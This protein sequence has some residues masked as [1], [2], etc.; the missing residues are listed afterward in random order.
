ML[1][2]EPGESPY[3]VRFQIFGFPVR[4]AWTFWIAVLVFGYELVD[5]IDWMLK[6]NSPGRLPL[7]LLWAVCLLVSILI[8]ELGHAFAFR[9]YGI[10]S[11]VILYHFGGLAVPRT[12][13][14]SSRALSASNLNAAQE[15]W[16]AAAGPLA[17]L[18][19]AA[20]LVGI[21]KSMDY[22]IEAF[23]DMPAGLGRLPY[24]LEGKPI[25]SGGLYAMV[26]FYVWPS[27][28]WALLN[29]VP[30]WP[31]D[32]GRIMRSLVL[33]T[34]GRVDQALWISLIAAG[35][36]AYIGFTGGQLFLGI[37]FVSLAITNYQMLQSSGGW[38]F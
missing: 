26:T 33:L 21:F 17:Q 37:L 13:F 29:L 10:E 14:T 34:G 24:V 19:S 4:I 1:L 30:V 23:D 16:I 27:V 20:V 35:V 25:D 3:D 5:Y 18:A 22:R 8:H 9:Q 2:H 11:S 31:L 12:T 36:M 32:G 6:D 15:L 28:L 38:R 7:L